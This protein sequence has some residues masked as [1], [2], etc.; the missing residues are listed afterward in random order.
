MNTRKYVVSAPV[1]V[2]QLKVQQ[3]N[4][5]IKVHI[6]TYINIWNRI[7]QAMLIAYYWSRK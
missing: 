2:G 1:A 5:W 6:S 3:A 4:K 7:L